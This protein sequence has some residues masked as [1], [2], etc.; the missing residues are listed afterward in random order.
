M[1]SSP[2]FRSR[3]LACLVLAVVLGSAGA[4]ETQQPEQGRISEPIERGSDDGYLSATELLPASVAGLV[5]IPD[6][7]AFCESWD[8]TNFG[9]LMNDPLLEPFLE[10]QRERSQRYFESIDAKVGLKPR[11]LYDIASGE[12]VVAWLPFEKDKR[13]PYS[14]CVIADTRGLK[15]QLGKTLDKIDQDLQ[16][17]GATRKEVNHNGQEVRVYSRKPKPGQLKIE[18]I[19]ITADDTRVIAADR[20]TVVFD[21]LDAIA[22]MPKAATIRSLED[23]QTVMTRSHDTLTGDTQNAGGTIGLEWFARP[24]QMGRILREVFEVDRGTQVDILNLLENQGFDAV[25]AAGGVV[26][27][28]VD[29]FD[30]LHR[31]FVLAPPTT[32]EP[33]RYR[34]GARMLQF[35]NAPLLDVPAW[36]D[37]EVSSFLRFNWKMEQAFWAAETVINEAF[38]EDLFRPMIQDIRDDEEGAQ[39]DIVEDVL[40]NLGDQ[41]ILITDSTLPATVDSDRM[42]VAIRVKNPEVIRQVVR[43]TMEVEPDVTLIDAVPGVQVWV[44]DRDQSEANFDTD[45]FVDLG[46]P[47]QVEE[48]RPPPLLEHWAIA[49]VDRG[50]GSDESYLMFSSHPELLIRTANRILEG[51]EAEPRPMPELQ[52]ILG[53]L[54]ELG[55]EQLALDRVVRLKLSLRVKYELLRKGELQNI[56]S[57]AASLLRRMFRIAETSDLEPLDASMLPP[58]EEIE[59]YLQPGGSFVESTADGWTLNGFILR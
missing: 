30:L 36:V 25:L 14:L 43:D 26:G 10:M 49:L 19:A 18:E 3:F 46:F 39:I 9:K 12:V 28:G 20:D 47:D 54:R 56:D 22:G 38:G 2:F 58:M 6:F 33:S 5:R 45:L 35:P 42:L 7:P 52:R 53:I 55:G 11:D 8:Q 34:L 37:D 32:V 1:N 51:P 15:D 50:E 13:R 29:R 21:L 24:F 31:G 59:K 16:G 44:V 40:P 17:Q 57:I 27:F 41:A 23:F 4:A 48:D